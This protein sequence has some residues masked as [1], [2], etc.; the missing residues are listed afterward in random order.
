MKA[1]RFTLTVTILSCLLVLLFGCQAAKQGGSATSVEKQPGLLR[2]GIS[3]NAPPL[4][5][6]KDGQITGLEAS[7]ARKLGNHLAKEVVFI[8]VPW[9]EQLTYLRED[10]TDIVMSGMTI[11]RE[12]G[13]LVDFATPYM[14]SGQI[15]LVRLEDRLRFSTGITSLVNTNYRIG[16]VSDTISDIFITASITDAN[17][18]TFPT[19]RKAVD[20]LIAKDI[21]V[22]VYD[23]PVICHYAAIHQKE[24]LVPILV[25]GTEEY[26]G[27]AISKNNKELLEQ[28]NQFLVSMQQSGALQEEIKA[29]IPY[30]YR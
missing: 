19:S 24:K 9:D 12:R 18:I 14:R 22:F 7:L 11:T 21:D 25:M 17:E 5:Y 10:K 4:I 20:A 2:V 3:A 27:W 6:K 28:A 15:M 16:T 26:L 1:L 8:E 30:L 29:W 23:A 13:Y